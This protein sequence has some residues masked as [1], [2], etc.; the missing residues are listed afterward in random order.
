MLTVEIDDAEMDDGDG[1]RREDPLQAGLGQG[2]SQGQGPEERPDR[3]HRRPV[4]A[5]L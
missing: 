2:L 4:G 3:Q 5:A 1:R